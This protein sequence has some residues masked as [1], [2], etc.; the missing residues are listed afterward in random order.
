VV[1]RLKSFTA[2]RRVEYPPPRPKVGASP[3]LKTRGAPG[4]VLLSPPVRRLGIGVC[5]VW[6]AGSCGTDA[7]GVAE[8]REIES[9]R[10]AAA[11][12]C[13]FADVE[14]CQRFYRDH[15]LH[16]V[17]LEEVNEVQVD[18]CVTELERAGRCATDAPGSAPAG[19]PE[20]VQTESEVTDVCTLILR[21]ELASACA[22][23]APSTAT[24]APAQQTDA[25]GG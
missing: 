1:G 11:A 22:F 13:G 14:Q 10:C 15:C 21:P 8:C 6:L 23:L 20:P 12:S 7:V 18:A 16:G 17:A 19:C 3:V 4:A 2:H 9:A 5:F 25:G 24:P